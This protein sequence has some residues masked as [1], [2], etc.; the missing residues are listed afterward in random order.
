[1]YIIYIFL[2]IYLYKEREG[3]R[4]GYRYGER[5]EVTVHTL[6]FNYYY[7]KFLSRRY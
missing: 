2:C 4:G 6:Y 3:E 7:I 1:M 5:E